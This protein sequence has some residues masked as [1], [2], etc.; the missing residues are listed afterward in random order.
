MKLYRLMSV[1][2]VLMFVSLCC[3]AFFNEEPPR[4]K[5]VIFR[6]SDDDSAF[7]IEAYL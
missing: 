5:A 6:D 2:V 7:D 1:Y 3:N 4:K